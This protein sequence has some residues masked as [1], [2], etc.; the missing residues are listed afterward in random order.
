MIMALL[1][2]MLLSGPAPVSSEPG[3]APV[4]GIEEVRDVVYGEAEGYWT[5]SQ[6]GPK[7]KSSFLFKKRGK[8]KPLEL[9][10]DLYLPEG[11]ERPSRPL[12]L[13]MHGGAYFV[14]HK[15]EPGQQEWCRYFASLGYVAASIDYRMG[16]HIRKKDIT[17]AENDAHEDAAAALSYLL[18]RDD[19][20]IDRDQVYL[21]GTSAGA[22]ISLRL[23]YEDA[24]ADRDFRIRAVANLWGYVYDLEVLT[25]ASVPILS[26]QSEHDPVVP[27]KKGYPL[28]ASTL[29]SKAWGTYSIHEKAQSLGI[30]CEHHPCSERRHK[31]HMDNK[32]V[33]TPRFYEICD[34]MAEFFAAA[35]KD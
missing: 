20:R 25:R 5:E 28:N 11:D 7:G 26:F 9:K 27:Y 1:S 22:A 19:L 30:P 29:I 4:F 2:S 13:M 23:A 15:D 8:P 12:L 17:R 31:L 35:G 6:D 24:T 21:A 14:G 18:A 3:T 16:Y 32:G 33:L 34:R 10:L